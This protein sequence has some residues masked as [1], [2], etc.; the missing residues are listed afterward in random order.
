[1]SDFGGNA[2][3]TGVP[4]SGW[5]IFAPFEAWS[6]WLRNNMGNMTAPPGYWTGEEAGA[7]PEG[8]RALEGDLRKRTNSR[9][10]RLARRRYL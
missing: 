8:P 2:K 5:A 3:E 1:M 7:K 9:S 4:N 10:S 6:E